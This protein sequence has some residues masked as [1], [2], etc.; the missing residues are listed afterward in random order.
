M[1]IIIFLI[2]TFLLLN[3]S[4]ADTPYI[5]PQSNQ[6]VVTLQSHGTPLDY[7]RAAMGWVDNNGKP[8]IDRQK[9]AEYLKNNPHYSTATK[10]PN[11]TLTATKTNPVTFTDNYG[12]K[13]SGN[14][15]TQ[16]TIPKTTPTAKL[17]GTAMVGQVATS[18]ANNLKQQGVADM[19]SQGFADSD[20]TK[21]A[22]GIGKMFD[23]TGLGGLL[24]DAI[25]GNDGSIANQV[26]A[27]L[28]QQAL[29]KAQRDFEE[30]QKQQ[31]IDTANWQN[32]GYFLLW[33]QAGDNRVDLVSM[34]VEKAELRQGQQQAKDIGWV[35]RN[36]RHNLVVPIPNIDQP[37]NSTWYYSRE[38]PFENEQQL[39]DFIA[40]NS[41]NIE[42]YMPT[43]ADWAK[44]M[45]DFLNQSNVNNQAIRDLINALWES[46]GLNPQNTQTT[47][48]GNT[49]NNTFVT[50]AYTPAGSNQAQ[51]TQFQV[52]PDGSVSVSTIPRPD[53]AP[54]TS[55]A[56]TRA[57]VGKP[58]STITTT[59]QNNQQHTATEKAPDVCKA[60]PNSLMCVDLGHMDY[61]DLKLPEN[62]IDLSFNPLNIFSSTGQ[63]PAD[64]TFSI[65][66]HTHALSYQQICDA[67][68][69]MRPW[70]ILFSMI[71]A[72]TIVRLT[73]SRA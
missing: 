15:R 41:I 73:I 69:K 7:R 72:F 62:K 52:N 10:S 65:R 70:V 33:A 55:Q 3:K 47:V 56:P 71:V 12:A 59:N 61:E 6:A 23:Y 48:I 31:N 50:D 8:Y 58:S 36:D 21:V 45:E 46:G 63:C 67:A 24:A 60:N 44:A 39:K 11:G 4:F 49:T 53:L 2:L 42:S 32:Y 66:G 28:Q 43:E 57:E 9:A 1:K 22:A 13:A 19:V 38:K 37:G 17:F 29:A 16:T 54:H 14:I 25:Y 68:I 51:Q 35:Y 5:P 34:V 40:Q 26:V 64:A 27:P 30:Y 18:H 20:W